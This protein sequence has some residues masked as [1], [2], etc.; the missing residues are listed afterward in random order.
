MYMTKMGGGYL[1][2]YGLRDAAT[3]ISSNIVE[4]FEKRNNKEF[5]RFLRIAKGST[6]E[7]RNRLYIAMTIE[8]VTNEEFT[9]IN[10]DLLTLGNKIGSLISYLDKNKK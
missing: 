7:V 6:G 4:G 3:S 9:A 2:G 1:T 10:Q 8:Y 5:A